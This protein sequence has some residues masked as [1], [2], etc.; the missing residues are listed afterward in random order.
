MGILEADNPSDQQKLGK[1][2]QNFDAARWDEACVEIVT[3]GNVHKFGQNHEL[4]EKLLATGDKTLVEASPKDK[5][6]G[7]GLSVKDAVHLPRRA[8]KGTNKLGEALMRA[9]DIL[10]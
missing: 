10:G 7:I 3:E 2:V 6:W 9:R 4:L 1:R 8:W 5:I